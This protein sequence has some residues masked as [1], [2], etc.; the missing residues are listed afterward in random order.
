MTKGAKLDG[1]SHNKWTQGGILTRRLGLSFLTCLG[2]LLNAVGLMAIF[3]GSIERNA[4]IATLP[5]TLWIGSITIAMQRSCSFS[6]SCCVSKSVG[7]S[8]QPKPGWLKFSD[9]ENQ[10]WSSDRSL[11]LG[12]CPVTYLWYHPTAD[13]WRPAYLSSSMK[14]VW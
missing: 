3:M 6:M 12:M 10:I 14:R 8:Q 9:S 2:S 11:R 1:S 4:S 7:L 5:L 13:S